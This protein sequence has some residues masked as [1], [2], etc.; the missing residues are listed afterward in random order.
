MYSLEER[1][2]LV[3][4]VLREGDRYN[5]AVKDLFRKTFPGKLLPHR[6]SVRDLMSR[7]RLTGAVTDR[8]RPGRPKKKDTDG[9]KKAK[10]KTTRKSTQKKPQKRKSIQEEDTVAVKKPHN[11]NVDNSNQSPVSLVALAPV[12]STQP[13]Q[14]QQQSDPRPEPKV[15]LAV[16]TEPVAKKSQ[17]PLQTTIE[18]VA[19]RKVD[20]LE[21]PES[22][23]E[24]PVRDQ[25]PVQV[26]EQV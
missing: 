4:H 14:S 15:S 25:D 18:K 23:D 24:E 2:F 19:D 20:E 11:E 16:N 8:P 12:V 22:P 1:I 21:S 17:P 13:A 9:S 26:Q 6:D 7:F 10:P 3:E 5:Q